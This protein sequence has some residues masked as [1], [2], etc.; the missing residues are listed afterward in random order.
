MSKKKKKAEG[1][2]KEAPAKE[3]PKEQARELS[4]PEALQ[5]ERDDLLSR[6]QRVSADYLNYQK[7]VQKDI[8]QAREYANE[9][10][11]KALL[12]VFDDMERALAAARENHDED[13]P[14]LA[15]MQLVHDKALETMG[16]FGLTVIE[17]EGRKFDPELH[18]AVLQQ[19]CDDRPPMTILQEVQ[20]GY[21]LKQR[22]IRPSSVIVAREPEEPP[23]AREAEAQE[24]C[25]EPQED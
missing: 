23:A 24:Q 18:S 8:A 22:T 13:D 7:R 14:L 15:G 12:G 10:L 5:L 1:E 19:P 25:E 9:E 4:E 21:R 6:L 17:A 11:V 16:R 3:E 2:E 20:K